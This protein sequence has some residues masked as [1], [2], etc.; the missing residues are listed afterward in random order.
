M[1]QPAARA[2]VKAPQQRVFYLAMDDQYESAVAKAWA[3]K[4]DKPIVY[5]IPIDRVT[6]EMVFVPVVRPY[7]ERTPM[8]QE[9]WDPQEQRRR[10]KHLKGEECM[11]ELIECRP[12]RASEFWQS[13]SGRRDATDAFSDILMGQLDKTG[14]INAIND[15]T[16]AHGVFPRTH[17]GS[18]DA[19]LKLTWGA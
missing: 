9:E 8:L 12:V 14:F 2:E 10:T 18:N 7:L 16:A 1:N 13:A 4:N 5:A 17:H 19:L 15:S 3:K 6:S 11:D